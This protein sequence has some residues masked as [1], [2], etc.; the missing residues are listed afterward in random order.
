MQMNFGLP[1]LAFTLL[2]SARLGWEAVAAGGVTLL[3]LLGFVPIRHLLKRVKL[4]HAYIV[5]TLAASVYLS[6]AVVDP[7]R[8][9][10][11]SDTVTW[12]L[13]RAVV[14]AMLYV[15]VR[16]FDRLLVIPMF[17]RGGTAQVPRF[18]HQLILIVLSIFVILMY[19]KAAFG[20]PI[21]DFLTGG[22]VVS[23]VIGLAL[24]ESLGNLFSG[25]VLQAAPPFVLGDFI[26][27]GSLEGRVV[28]MTWRA[29]T[30]H[31]TDDNYVVIPNGTIAK[32][33]ITNY[34]APSTSSA[35]IVKI[36]LDYDLP[37]CDA[38]AVLQRAALE[39]NG[40]Q[41]TPPPTI[42]ILDYADSSIV[43]GIKFWIAEPQR[44]LR[45][46]HEVRM[47]AWYRL[48]EKGY[49]IPFPVRTVEVINH[50]DKAR[51]ER[52]SH[53]A[54][55]EESF[56]SIPLLE[57]LSAAQKRMLAE[58]AS[59]VQLAPGQVLF[60]QDDSGDSLYVI[61]KGKAEVLVRGA[62]GGTSLLATLNAGDV[63]GEMSALTG[64]PRTATIRAA[65]ALSMVQLDK[66]DFKRLID[67]DPSVM[68]K[69]SALIARRN[70]ERELH[71]QGLAADS[72]QA[73]SVE[74]QQRSILDR[75]IRFFR[76]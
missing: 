1:M 48:K 9:K 60:E 17:T 26:Q 2:S 54:M 24:Q 3:G 27:A 59:N 20:W 46:E 4:I 49:N 11:S 43:Y 58:G 44:H 42:V 53:I 34:H 68:E 6:V 5:F 39:T 74:V 35:R 71:L 57:P 51:R 33:E 63:I 64:Q 52:E 13:N 65:T 72:P 8:L 38:V 10:N 73:G 14:G 70:V 22:A 12:W 18:I 61:R 50:R 30:L 75:M 36:G 7:A 69:I 66:R 62:G 31:T 67:S 40:V 23:I 37:P 32:Q 15:M 45:V 55:R 29:V 25:L 56:I 16:V 76:S 41:A 19:G 28:D 47:H 21:S